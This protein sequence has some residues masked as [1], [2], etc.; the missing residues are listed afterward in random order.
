MFMG[1]G[2]DKL[3]LLCVFINKLFLKLAREQGVRKWGYNHVIDLRQT[4]HNLPIILY[5]DGMRDGRH[6]LEVVGVGRIG[7]A[8]T[9]KIL[10]EVIGHL[11]NARIYRID[12]CVDL[13]GVSVW[14]LAQISYLGPSQNFQIYRNR[15]GDSVYLQRSK[16]KT[17]LLYDKK[18]RL[19]AEH[20]PRAT[21]YASG[22]ELTRIEI[23]FKGAGVPFKKLRDIHW[24]ADINLLSGLKFR[25]LVSSSN[26]K[27]PLRA[28]AAAHLAT[29]IEDFG[30]HAA[31]KQF[32]SS[33]R[34]YIEKLFL[35]DVDGDE[36]P[37]IRRRMRKAIQDWLEDRIRFPSPLFARAS[38]RH[39][40]D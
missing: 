25:R 22:D 1:C 4:D 23:Q 27:K 40:R 5:C 28:M 30:L 20:D 18:R 29:Q 39:D 2:I 10:R 33:H 6:K 15:T 16:A 35:E 3:V 34:A 13:P 19:R 37:D 12:F 24:Y 38:I 14:S 9:L 26:H 7:H 21:M 32:P 17:I 11:S 8:R 31:L 36:A